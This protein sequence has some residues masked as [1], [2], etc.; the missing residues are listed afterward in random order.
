MDNRKFNVDELLSGIFKPIQ[1]RTLR[2]VFNQRL[3][4]LEITQTNACEILKMEFRTLNGIL[5]GT[6]KRIDVI[7]LI[8]ISD[9]LK[10]SKELVIQL[11]IESLESNFPHEVSLSPDKI[12]FIKANFDL[13][14]LKKANFIDSVT[15]FPE[16][17]KKITSFFGLKTI[18]DYER[19]AV[20][21]AFSAGLVEPKNKL[22]RAFWIQAAKTAFEEIDNPHPYDRKALVEY[23]PQIRWHSTSVELGLKNV[24]RD[25]YRTGV[26]IIYQ[27]SLPALHLRGATFCVNG[28]PCI[29][30]TNYVGF[31]P[32]LWF[33]LIHELFHVIFDWDEIRSN[34][35]HLSGI[36]DERLTVIEKEKEADHFAREYL[37][38]KEK[39]Q[40]IKP[41]LN[42][43]E[44]VKEFAHN[45]HVHPSFIYVFNAHDTGSRL[46][47]ARAKTETPDMTSL[48]IN[49]ENSW[50]NPVSIREYVKSIESNLYK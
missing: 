14:V 27:P 9:F 17:E 19:P 33:A 46:A 3:D 49:I 48:F 35:Y 42:D 40:K 44:Y 20:D 32:T 12:E 25:I 5:D 41:Y 8:K 39:T 45:N 23:F 11:Y 26:T 15:D 28:K 36:D 16:I 4:E 34:Q 18:Y 30:L 37:F 21:V 6:Q 2:E 13:A 29:V 31:Y 43:R 24:I 7:N 47:W 38:S 10:S 1:K 22:T 50:S